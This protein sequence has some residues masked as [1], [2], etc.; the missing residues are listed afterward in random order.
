MHIRW[1]FLPSARQMGRIFRTWIWSLLCTRHGAPFANGE[2]WKRSILCL[3]F[4]LFCKG[5]DHGFSFAAYVKGKLVIDIAAGYTVDEPARNYTRDMLQPVFS[6]GKLV[7]SIVVAKAVSEGYLKYSD[8]VA[9]HWPDFAQGGK[10]GVTVADVLRHDS[11]VPFCDTVED[12]N[13]EISAHLAS[14]PRYA[15]RVYHAITRGNVLEEV[16]VR[17]SGKSL[18]EHANELCAQSSD[19]TCEW[20]IGYAKNRPDLRPRVQKAK[21]KHPLVG[22]ALFFLDGKLGFVD[23]LSDVEEHVWGTLLG[24][25]D[26]LFGKTVPSFF[27]KEFAPANTDS[28]HSFQASST[29]SVS[30]AHSLAA[31]ASQVMSNGNV[32]SED[33]KREAWSEPIARLEES[34]L[35][36]L[37][38]TR[39]G[40]GW[41]TARSQSYF[42]GDEQFRGWT[43]AGGSLVLMAPPAD[44]TFAYVPNVMQPQVFKIDR[45]ADLVQAFVQDVMRSLGTTTK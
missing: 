14:S 45:Q 17:A 10:E 32:I 23:A 15:G 18:Q 37:S 13:N 44:V 16:L 30:N 20:V 39:G 19:P 38:L 24:L 11:G 31:L 1:C 29:A 25:K 28:H 21:Y 33:V 40:F 7:E 4:V 26:G 36:N 2:T 34:L 41:A 8:P 5:R 27:L 9:K 43:G 3:I 12:Y 22:V 6:S 42:I 35:C